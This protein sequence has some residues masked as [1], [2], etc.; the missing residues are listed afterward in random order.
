MFGTDFYSLL[1]YT[2]VV[3][4]SLRISVDGGTNFLPR[5]SEQQTDSKDSKRYKIPDIICGDFD[6]VDRSTLDYFEQLGSKI[7]LTPDQDETDFTK[8]VEIVFQV[9]KERGYSFDVILA[10][11]T[12]GGRPDHLLSNFN[13]LHKFGYSS[14]PVILY[15]IGTSISWVLQSGFKHMITA[16]DKIPSPPEGIPWCSLVP[17]T[18]DVVTSTTGLKWNLNRDTLK[19]GSFISTSNE[20]ASRSTTVSVECNSSLLWSMKDC[21]TII[22]SVLTE[23]SNEQSST[24]L[25][26]K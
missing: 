16:I 7:I 18:G 14:T 6:S 15:D 5:A 8:A 2:H 25:S 1:T 3:T 13:T 11:N 12:I 17:L 10:I 20:F 9:E 4:A 23:E 22:E 26:S 24:S 21:L 19:F